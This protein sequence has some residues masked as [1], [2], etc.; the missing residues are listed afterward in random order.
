VPVPVR[1]LINLTFSILRRAVRGA[2]LGG[3]RPGSPRRTSGEAKKFDGHTTTRGVVAD[4]NERVSTRWAT[5]AIKPRSG[6]RDGAR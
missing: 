3:L 1:N 6:E 4:A 2:G 5:A